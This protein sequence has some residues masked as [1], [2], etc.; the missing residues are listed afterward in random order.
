MK[1]PPSFLSG[2]FENVCVPSSSSG[3]TEQVVA[4]RVFDRHWSCQLMA[5]QSSVWPAVRELTTQWAVTWSPL[6]LPLFL[7]HV[8]LLL[9]IR[10][11]LSGRF[12]E[13]K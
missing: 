9:D 1:Q 13:K 6:L 3:H 5:L 12:K 7:L 2:Y 11:L 8:V 4:H 10:R